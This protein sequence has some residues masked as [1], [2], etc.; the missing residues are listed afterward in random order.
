MENKLEKSELFVTKLIE[1]H[2]SGKLSSDLAKSEYQTLSKK[3]LS[4]ELK[5]QIL[6]II[7]NYEQHIQDIQELAKQDPRAAKAAQLIFESLLDVYKD[8]SGTDLRQEA[9]QNEIS[10]HLS[11]NEDIHIPNKEEPVHHKRLIYTPGSVRTYNGQDARIKNADGTWSSISRSGNKP[12]E[13]Q[14]G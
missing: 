7:Q 6:Q 14:N 13:G 5:T 9:T 3:E 2:D 4:E 11:P 8:H 10:Q 12:E 1:L